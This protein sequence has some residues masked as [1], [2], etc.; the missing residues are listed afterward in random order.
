MSDVAQILSQIEHGDPSAAE[1]WLPLVYE[2]LKKL[3]T[4]KM[5]DERPDH[6]LRATALVHEAYLR[7]VGPNDDQSW[8]RRGHFVAAA[9]ES[10]GNF[11]V[12]HRNKFSDGS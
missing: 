9:A 5:A 3:A 2:H 6:T 7:L 12:Q 10:T 8:D 11:Q 1:Q 4:A